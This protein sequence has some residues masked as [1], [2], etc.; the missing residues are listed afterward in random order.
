MAEPTD[1]ELMERIQSRDRRAHFLLKD[2]YSARLRDIAFAILRSHHKA[3]DATRQVFDICWKQSDIF[4]L[5]RDRSVAL[6]LYELTGFYARE[7]LRRWPWSKQKNKVLVPAPA[8]PLMGWIVVI[9]GLVVLGLG[10]YAGWLT[11]QNRRL[12]DQVLTQALPPQAQIQRLY[13]DWQ[14][15]PSTQSFTLRDPRAQTDILAQLLWSPTAGQAILLTT[16]LQPAPTGQIYQLWAIG[17]QDSPEEDSIQTESAGT[18]APPSDGTVQW[19]SQSLTLKAPDRFILTTEPMGGSD[20][21]TGEIRL[22]SAPVTSTTAPDAAQA[23]PGPNTNPENS[24]GS[25]PE[26]A[27]PDRRDPP[28]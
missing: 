26:P 10:S 8:N 2:R 6:W 21:P 5:E 14:Q 17:P 3:E 7:Q 11:W 16:E 1:F 9:L 28:P 13:Q 18:F 12:Q 20:Q 22:E 15:Q 24:T 25:A 4:D 19:L 27:S 23:A